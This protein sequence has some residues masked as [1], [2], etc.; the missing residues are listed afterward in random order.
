[1]AFSPSDSCCKIETASQLRISYVLHLAYLLH[2]R[3]GNSASS[4]PGLRARTDKCHLGAINGARGDRSANI[5]MQARTP[6]TGLL[7]S[8][9]NLFVIHRGAKSSIKIVRVWRRRIPHGIGRSR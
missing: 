2:R 7:G 6:R 1:M 3:L 5:V 4:G 8:V 9:A